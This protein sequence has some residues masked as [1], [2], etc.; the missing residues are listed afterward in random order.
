M[1]VDVIVH[2]MSAEGVRVQGGGVRYGLFKSGLVT[3]FLPSVGVSAFYDRAEHAVFRADHYS[4]NA[5][6]SWDLPIVSPFAGVGYDNTKVKIESAVL[7]G[8]AG[9]SATANGSRLAAGADFTPF[10]FLRL[11][12]AYTLINKNSGAMGSL[13]FKF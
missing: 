5:S 7:P 4:V 13:L 12:G 6:A 2:G 3:K 11:R 10:P 8:V 9:M 1:N